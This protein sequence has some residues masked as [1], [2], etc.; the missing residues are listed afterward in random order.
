MTAAETEWQKPMNSEQFPVYIDGG[1]NYTYMRGQEDRWFTMKNRTILMALALFMFSPVRAESDIIHDQGFEYGSLTNCLGCSSG[2]T[3]M[4]A[5]DFFHPEDAS[6]E[7]VEIWVITGS[8][9]LE[10]YHLEVRECVSGPGPEVLWS[11][12]V[13]GVPHTDTGLS[14][15]GFNIHHAE[16]TLDETQHF[17]MTGGT[18]YWLC[19]QAASPAPVYWLSS[20]HSRG[21]MSHFSQDGGE[22]WETSHEY[23]GS[24]LDQFMVLKGTVGIQ[25]LTGETWGALK[26]VFR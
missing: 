26:T 14:W 15:W 25:S 7:E 12:V 9:S 22:S 18:D 10:E 5:D 19:I 23:T 16:I 20:S 11:A 1:S 8:T 13:T 17:S 2:Q 3:W 21:L 4:A 6:L 24:A